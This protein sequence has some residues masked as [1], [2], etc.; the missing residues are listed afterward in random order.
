MIPLCSLCQA[1]LG[2]TSCSKCHCCL[3]WWLQGRRKRPPV[4]V[5]T[6]FG[7]LCG[8]PSSFTA[9]RHSWDCW[10]TSW[11]LSWGTKQKHWVSKLPTWQHTY[12]SFILCL[13]FMNFHRSLLMVGRCLGHGDRTTLS[14]LASKHRAPI[15]P[16]RTS[17]SE[18]RSQCCD[19][20]RGRLCHCV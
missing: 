5:L 8:S 14:P 6:F 3:G 1:P 12:K 15:G 19:D 18:F 10:W 7:L 20:K 4:W 11:P 9:S 16:Q 2:A 13:A 17:S